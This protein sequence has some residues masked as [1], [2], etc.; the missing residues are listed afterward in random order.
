MIRPT[1][2][3]VALC[4]LTVLAAPQE[5]PI[6]RAGTSTVPVYATV[7]DES[8][9]LVTDLSA[10]DFE[11]YD[12]GRRQT[13]SLFDNRERPIS[14]V[15]MLDR[16]VSMRAHFGLLEDAAR[17]FVATLRPGDRVRIGSF[18][19]EI[20]IEPSTFTDDRQAL[21][22]II[23]GRLVRAGATPLWGAVTA[24]LDAL[25]D[26]TGHRVLVVFTDGRDSPG[27]GHYVPFKDTL[28]RVSSEPPIVYG[29]G[30][31]YICQDSRRDAGGGPV[32]AS[33]QHVGAGP[34]AGSAAQFPRP[35]RRGPGPQFPPRPI[36]RPGSRPWE[37]SFGDCRNA[38]PDPD[39]RRLVEVGGGG[40]F[41][42]SSTDDLT[43]TFERVA[44]EIHT[45][46]LLGFTPTEL[47]GELHDLEVRVTRPG[48]VVRA[49]RS[50]LASSE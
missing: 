13:V 45:Q 24:G 23:D 22:R 8:G 33:A 7:V 12:N 21:L 26:E 41:E 19:D 2:L 5:Q 35:G 37:P 50:Y 40:Y 18:A 1:A 15:V 47:D 43:A 30:L 31:D 10:D 44:H 16:S 49:R 6:F 39:L 46:Y 34:I 11:I 27:I 4:S 48:L 42:L 14:I 29:I 3:V 17:A 32:L 36:P 28:A 25:A 38:G 9:R 20:R